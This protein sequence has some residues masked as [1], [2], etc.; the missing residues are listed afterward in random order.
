MLTLNSAMYEPATTVEPIVV[1]E[2]KPQSSWT[3]PA[4]GIIVFLVGIGL[5]AFTFTLAFDQFK[6]APE[7]AMGIPP[8]KPLDIAQ[9]VQSFAGLI[10][11]VLLLLVMAIVGAIVANRGIKMYSDSRAK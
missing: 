6:V 8:G 5:L 3:G 1:E 11:H 9:V 2:K 4:F 7:R 10:F